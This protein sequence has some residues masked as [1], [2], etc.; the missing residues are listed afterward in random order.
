MDI[1]SFYEVL[2]EDESHVRCTLCNAKLS[3][4]GAGKRGFGTS[5]MNRHLSRHHHTHHEKLVKEKEKAV[6]RKH[7]VIRAMTKMAE[8]YLTPPPTTTDVERL[9][10]TAGDIITNERN[11]LLPA[12]AERLLFLRENLS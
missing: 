6:K 4:G 10:S 2:K 11:R 7:Q 3:R 12:T 1:W 5:N 8:I 9:F